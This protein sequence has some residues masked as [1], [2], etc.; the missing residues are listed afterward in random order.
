MAD[1]KVFTQLRRE[2]RSLIKKIGQIGPVLK[3]SVSASYT[4]CGKPNC[5]CQDDPPQLHGPYWQWSTSV[6]GKTVSRRLNDQER[7]LYEQW[8][9]NRKRLEAVI[10]DM[11]ALALDAAA[12]T[13][14]DAPRR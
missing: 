4:R 14:N 7:K 11:H 9:N 13:K 5:S 6:D 3:G 1:P 2:H 8:V 12:A 10:Q